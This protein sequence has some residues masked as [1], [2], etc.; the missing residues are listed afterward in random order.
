MS[1][2]ELAHD[3][4]TV[5]LADKTRFRSSARLSGFLAH[6]AIEGGNP[7]V[8][9]GAHVAQ[10]IGRLAHRL[11]PH[12]VSH[13]PSDPLGH[14]QSGPSQGPQVFDNR[15]AGHWVVRRQLGSGQGP[16]GGQAVEDTTASGVAKGGEDGIIVRHPSQAV[17]SNAGAV[18]AHHTPANLESHVDQTAG[19]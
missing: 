11:G 15:L 3:A 12:P 14:Q 19:S 17:T 7:P 9:P 2:H 5:I 18:A 16:V 8:P 13:I 6:L 1:A 4:T 10:P